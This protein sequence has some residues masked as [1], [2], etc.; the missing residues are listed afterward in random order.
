MEVV[1]IINPNLRNQR[2]TGKWIER[3]CQAAGI[4]CTTTNDPRAEGDITVVHGP[5]YALSG[6][7]G[8]VLWL[9]RCWYGHPE[10][11][12]TLGWKRSE[13]VRA[14]LVGDA[15]RFHI[16]EDMGVV[17]LEPERKER[18]V[19]ALDDYPQNLKGSGLEWDEYR[20]HPAREQHSEPLGAAMRRHGA[21]IVGMGTCGAQAKLAGLHVTSVDND[22]IINTF[23][24]RQVWAE[25][26][27]WTQ[28]HWRELES[29][30]PIR[31]LIEGIGAYRA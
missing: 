9:D 6:K 1:N 2:E 29:G 11:W 18:T 23:L 31:D 15:K 13:T 5:N 8:N 21:A 24:P 30:W 28:Y 22:N 4:N 10:E 27:A 20:G 7:Q 16:H 25:Q 12:V 17:E 26:L 3:G 19:I 14:Y